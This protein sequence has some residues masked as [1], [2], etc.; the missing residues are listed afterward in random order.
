M[1]YWQGIKYGDCILSILHKFT[2]RQDCGVISRLIDI[3]THNII[4]WKYPLG[5]TTIMLVVLDGIKGRLQNPRKQANKQQFLINL[6]SVP[7][8]VFCLESMPWLP[9]IQGS[10]QLF[11]PQ[12]AFGL[13]SA[14]QQKPLLRYCSN[15]SFYSEWESRA[16][17]KSN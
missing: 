10:E 16:Q 14:Q 8:S 3:L 17:G 11:P 15:T 6:T 5:S 1:L 7:G 9:Y 4:V 12:L 13:V 2:C